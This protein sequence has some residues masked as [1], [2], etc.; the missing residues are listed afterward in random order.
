M[1]TLYSQELVPGP[2]STSINLGGSQRRR[3]LKHQA[4]MKGERTGSPFA[5]DRKL[6]QPIGV[7]DAL[8]PEPLVFTRITPD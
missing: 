6:Y 5:P 4:E 7:L 3:H 1:R 8:A 2:S